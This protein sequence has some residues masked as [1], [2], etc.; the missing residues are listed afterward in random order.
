MRGGRRRVGAAGR[1]VA[2]PKLLLFDFDGTV[3]NTLECGREILNLLAVEFKYRRLDDQ[4]VALA[5]DMR[6]SELM[7]YLGIPAT[8][9]AKISKRGKEELHRRMDGIQP[10]DGMLEILRCLHAEG[11]QLGILTSNSAENV[12]VFLKKFDIEL[13]DFVCT[14]SK[15]TGKGRVIR[16]ILKAHQLK[17][18]QVLLVGD[19]VRDIEAA[20]ET[21]IHMAAVTWGYNSLK[22]IRALN[23]DHV[24]ETP[25][26]LRALLCGDPWSPSEGA[27]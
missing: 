3:A 13:F 5:R 20:Q 6:N 19:E 14:S 2:R 15:L 16:K 4:D 8:R 25:E 12:T 7:K 24:L 17:P 10:F 9:L 11:F 27:P 21:G 23:P 18:R 1:L 22:A 26:A